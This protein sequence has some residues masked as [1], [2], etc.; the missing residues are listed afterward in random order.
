MSFIIEWYKTVSQ[1]VFDF[2][3]VSPLCPLLK[4]YQHGVGPV[5]VSVRNLSVKIGRE[6]IFLDRESKHLKG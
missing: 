2:I 6:P 3:P 4:T 1:Q 5:C